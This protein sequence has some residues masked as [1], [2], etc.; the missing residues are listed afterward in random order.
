MQLLMRWVIVC[1]LRDKIDNWASEW[2]MYGNANKGE[3]KKR[4]L[5]QHDKDSVYRL[6]N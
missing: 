4:T 3:T 6:Y 5:E 1:G 2:T